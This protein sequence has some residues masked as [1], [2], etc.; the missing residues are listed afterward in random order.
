MEPVAD[1][2]EKDLSIPNPRPGLFGD[3]AAA[4][5]MV[6]E[7]CPQPGPRVVDTRSIFYKDTEG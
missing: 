2:S 5:V 3:G 6:G 7:D 1:S 4:V